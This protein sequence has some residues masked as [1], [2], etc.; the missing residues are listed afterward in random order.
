MLINGSTFLEVDCL[1]DLLK[2]V[3]EVIKI[4]H[5]TLLHLK[6][7]FACV[8]TL[9]LPTYFLGALSSLGV[10]TSCKSPS[11]MKDCMRFA[12]F[13]VWIHINLRLALNFVAAKDN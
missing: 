4:Y 6:D 1:K 12:P 10:G 8:Y 5:N 11:S 3:R 9:T 13:M 2:Y 7:K